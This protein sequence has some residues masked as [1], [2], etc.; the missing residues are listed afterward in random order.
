MVAGLCAILALSLPPLEVVPF[1]ATVPFLVIT[2]LSLALVAR[3]DLLAL[4]ILALMIGGGYFVFT[5][6]GK[7]FAWLSNTAA[8]PDLRNPALASRL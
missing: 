8:A 5:L 1:G 7:G 3:D 6:L 4:M 2:G